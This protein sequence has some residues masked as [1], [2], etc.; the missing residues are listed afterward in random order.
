MELDGPQD[1]TL[2]ATFEAIPTGV[3]TP[4]TS[5]AAV[6]NTSQSSITSNS[7]SVA[8]DTLVLV[9]V[10]WSSGTSGG[11][12]TITG[13]KFGG[14]DLTLG[15][16]KTFHGEG[17]SGGSR[18]VGIYPFIA[19]ANITNGTAVVTFSAATTFSIVNVET[20][21]G[22][23]TTSPLGTFSD[24]A[25]HKDGS[26]LPSQTLT[27]LD[28]NE[29]VVDLMFQAPHSSYMGLGTGQTLL[30]Q[31]ASGSNNRAQSSYKQA[32]G[33]TSVTMN[34]TFGGTLPSQHSWTHLAVPIRPA[35]GT[36][37]ATHTITVTA[38]ANGAI[39]PAGPNVTVNHGAD[40]TFTITPASGY[41]V[42]DVK[43]DGASVGAVTSYTIT[44]VQSNRTIVATFREYTSSGQV[45]LDGDIYTESSATATGSFTTTKTFK[46]GSGADRL[47]L[48]GI[49]WQSGGTSAATVSSVT[50][51]PTGGSAVNLIEVKSQ[52]VA[53]GSD[54]GP[55]YPKGGAAIYRLP[56]TIGPNQTGTIKVT[57]ST[58]L[59]GNSGAVVVGMANFKGVDQTTPYGTP[60]SSSNNTGTTAISTSV[61]SAAG[62]M[63]FDVVMAANEAVS[64]NPA[65]PSLT[66]ATGQTQQWSD[67]PPGT[68]S[69]KRATRGAASTKAATT[70]GS[71][72]MNWTAGTNLVWAH[73]AV[74][75]NPA[76]GTPPVTYTITA[77]A[78][79]NGTIAPSGAVTVNQGA[80]QVFTINP[81]AGYQVDD[82]KVDGTSVGAVISY[83]FT[84][85]QADH[86]IAATFKAISTSH[87]LTYTARPQRE[88][89][90]P[91]GA[92]R[93]SWREWRCG[94]GSGQPRLP[95]R[96]ME[97][98]PSHPKS[99]RHQCAG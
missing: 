18:S 52:T 76:D 35:G 66:P 70:A 90:R 60:N 29:L 1:H 62:G 40:Q 94:Y 58:A 41:Q 81:A 46:T 13:I 28:G 65:P 48:V 19:P 63:V 95:L 78:G 34:W 30:W 27:G 56:N 45:E 15:E 91:E 98:R 21:T 51:T 24:G 10:V 96:Q 97:R 75:L 80:D 17:S 36:P 12:K 83:T 3:V 39:S 77:T 31:G 33:S 16:G 93:K 57:F 89:H 5:P 92:D 64:S 43:V 86:T 4:G 73:V 85:V 38:G 68:A 25:T 54:S 47:S 88:H 50:F 11:T 14:H 84:N 87:T 55:E 22:V 99:H 49:S 7:V 59:S 53:K 67:A 23:D 9:T 61:T 69:Y 44:N 26:Q 8:K 74:P 20:F 71:V 37:P 79:D 42:E 72:A 2:V 82:V 6:V 32:N